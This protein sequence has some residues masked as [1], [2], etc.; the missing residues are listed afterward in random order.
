M[1]DITQ[2]ENYDDTMS[3]T[4]GK[5]AGALSKAQGEIHG[6][7]KDSTN[8]F[9]KSSYADLAAVIEA[10]REQLSKYG[11]AVIQTNELSDSGV[12]VV[13]TLVHES[14]EWIRGKLKMNPVKNDPQGVGSCITYARRY[15]RAAA[16]GIA[17]VDDDGNAAT[18]KEVKQV[19]PDPDALASLSECDSIEALQ[20]HWKALTAEQRKSIGKQRLENFKKRL[21]E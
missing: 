10:S 3:P 7:I 13:T 8:P 19:E 11:L 17:Q 14:G 2:T 15:A 21:S 5:L 20:E 4:I 9:F 1:N 6:A 18:R 16:I 12:V